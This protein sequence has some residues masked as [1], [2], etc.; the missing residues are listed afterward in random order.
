ME[1]ITDKHINFRFDRGLRQGDYVSMRKRLRDPL[2]L[3]EIREIYKQR[4]KFESFFIKRMKS[5][6]VLNPGEGVEDL[7]GQ[8][9]IFFKT[10]VLAFDKSSCDRHIEKHLDRI[11]GIISG[12]KGWFNYRLDTSIAEA[13]QGRAKKQGGLESI[14][15]FDYKQMYHAEE[16]PNNIDIFQIYSLIGDTNLTRYVFLK[17]CMDIPKWF[18]ELEFDVKRVESELREILS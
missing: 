8:F 9:S 15:D 10:V 4:K 7:K 17:T 3:L 6:G 13:H 11:T 16:E 5:K 12:L 1:L 14:D 2:T 18:L